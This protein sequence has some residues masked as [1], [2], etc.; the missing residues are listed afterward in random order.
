[1]RIKL[2]AKAVSLS[3]GSG[4]HRVSFDDGDAITAK[5]VIIATGARYNRLPLG[6][7][8]E[9]EGVGVYYRGGLD[10]GAARVRT[11]PGHRKCGRGPAPRRH[12]RW[13]CPTGHDG[14]VRPAGARR[15]AVITRTPGGCGLA[16]PFGTMILNGSRG[17]ARPCPA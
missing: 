15:A 10:G 2:P 1:V 12:G 3:S 14:P 5:S 7:L 8:A 6:R 4:V 16:R 11:P 9:F 17:V 13:Q